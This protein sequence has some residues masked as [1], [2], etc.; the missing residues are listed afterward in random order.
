M[1]KR[2]LQPRIE[3]VLFRGRVILLWGARRVGKTTMAQSLLAAHPEKRTRYLNCDLIPVQQGLSV[4]DAVPL[5]NFIGDY[6]FV[7]L[8]EAQNVP[9]IGRAL[10]ILVDTYPEIQILATGSSALY[11]ADQVGEPLTGRAFRFEL[12]PLS[13]Q[14]LAPG[15]GYSEVAPY[16][17]SLLRFGAYPEA[18]GLPEDDARA[19]LIELVSTY[20][21]K[22]IF[23]YLGTR[24]SAVVDSL[25]RLLALQVG[26]E[27]SFH[28]IGTILGLDY[29]TVERYIDL[30]EKSYIV[31]RLRGFS[32]NLRKEVGKT[33]KVY[34][35][36]VGVRNAILQAFAPLS[37]RNDVGAL[38]EN[39]CIVERRKKLHY[40]G[41]FAHTYFWRTYD[42]KEID[43][44]EERDGVLTGYECKWSPTASYKPP[45]EF[46]ATYPGSSITRID[47]S[48]YWRTLM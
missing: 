15:G 10:K 24:K 21:Y 44:L 4:L 9:D 39:F 16:I 28:E 20:L 5:R 30:L 41:Q 2:L 33:Q 7:V 45:A 11:L 19:Y 6:D 31:F 13:L 40:A 25:V 35:F 26:S 22:D 34:F 18:F 42:K 29:R 47:R 32:R 48:N 3:R 23:S 12:F 17:D 36:D 46:L 14:E 8:D 37:L 1:I 43:Y 38:W 27:V